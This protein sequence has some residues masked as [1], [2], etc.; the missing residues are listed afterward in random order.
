MPPK[1]MR[2]TRT[3]TV[4]Q[5][6]VLD[7]TGGV[8]SFSV[9]RSTKPED[10]SHNEKRVLLLDSKSWEDMGSPTTITVTIV[11]GDALNEEE[12]TA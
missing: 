6:S 3:Q 7:V 8:V 1:G 4:M 11:P 10:Y 9:E 2:L 12:W 5:F